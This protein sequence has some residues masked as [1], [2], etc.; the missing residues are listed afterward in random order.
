MMPAVPE[1]ATTV[2]RSMT[3]SWVPKLSFSMSLTRKEGYTV[4]Q[5]VHI[6]K[7]DSRHSI[8]STCCALRRK[9]TS[10]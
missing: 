4:K 3:Y 6:S 9:S 7:G 2:L 5:G 8:D 10:V 1:S